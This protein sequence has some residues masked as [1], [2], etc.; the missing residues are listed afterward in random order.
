[1]RRV[2][3]IYLPLWPIERWQRAKA[4]QAHSTATALAPDGPFALIEEARSALRLYAVNRQASRLGLRPHMGLADA[5]AIYPHLL[6]QWAEPDKDREALYDLARWCIRY[7]PWVTVEGRDGLWL[8]VSGCAHLFGGEAQLCRDIL[9]RL[10]AFQITAHIGLAD[11][12]GAAW[13]LSRYGKKPFNIADIGQTAQALAS[14]RGFPCRKNHLHSIQ[15][16]LFY[17]EY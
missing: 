3:S 5:R 15:Y 4:Q 13:A 10:K 11:T 14:Y 12:P 1:M 2:I 7:T 9:K 6:A 8:D 17:Q 16:M